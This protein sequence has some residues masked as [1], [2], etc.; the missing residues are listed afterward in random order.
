M[1]AIV[2]QS[3]SSRFLCSNGLCWYFTGFMNLNFMWLTRYVSLR[4]LRFF[5]EQTNWQTE[6]VIELEHLIGWMTDW[7]TNRVLKLLQK[8]LLPLKGIDVFYRKEHEYTISFVECFVITFWAGKMNFGF[9][10]SSF[11]WYWI[12]EPSSF[13]ILTNRPTDRNCEL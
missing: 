3:I 6:L 1:F 10:T 5:Y 11:S 7:L 4:Q 8:R 2:N 9:S 12:I 13:K